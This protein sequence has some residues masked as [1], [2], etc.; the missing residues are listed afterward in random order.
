M[1]FNVEISGDIETINTMSISPESAEYQSDAGFESDSYFSSEKYNVLE[2]AMIEGEK[3]EHWGFDID[4]NILHGELWT[5]SSN[6]QGIKSSIKRYDPSSLSKTMSDDELEKQEPLRDRDTTSTTEG[7]YLAGE[8]DKDGSFFAMQKDKPEGVS[9]EISNTAVKK[10]KPLLKETT[11][12]PEFHCKM[13]LKEKNLSI[14]GQ[15]KALKAWMKKYHLL[16]QFKKI[17]GHCRIPSQCDQ[18]P[19]LG[20]W[21]RKQQQD[22]KMGRLSGAQEKLLDELDFDWQISN[23]WTEKFQE[24]QQFKQKNGHCRVPYRYTADPSL[25]RWVDTQRQEKKNQRLPLYREQ[26]L[27][28]LGFEWKGHRKTW[29]EHFQ[30]LEHFKVEHGDCRVPHNYRANPSLGIWVANQRREKKNN[31]ISTDREKMLND[32]GFEWTPNSKQKSRKT[33]TNGEESSAA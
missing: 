24:L 23:S 33:T 31:R 10:D 32:L 7:N 8:S 25:G 29:M 20:R 27:N 22:K 17:N 6:N 2:D 21:I 16:Q 1:V 30:L 11:S 26:L 5:A 13:R 18:D 9:T 3:I 12:A 15:E 4:D 19:S 14:E 28:E